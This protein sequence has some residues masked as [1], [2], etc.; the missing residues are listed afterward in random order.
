[1]TNEERRVI[2]ALQAHTGGLIVT[3]Q[4]I[5]DAQLKLKETLEGPP[6]RPSSR[7]FVL[8]AAAVVALIAG[9]VGIQSL[10]SDDDST[11]PPADQPADP[12]AAFLTGAMP[13]AQL[14]QG[15][16]IIGDDSVH[17]RFSSPN[18]V[19]FDA[20]GTL[21]HGPAVQGTYAI[22]GDVVSV[23]VDGGYKDCGSVQFSMRMRMAGSNV[24]HVVPTRTGAAGDCALPE[25]ELVAEQ[26]LP[27]VEDRASWGP[28]EKGDV[29]WPAAGWQPPRGSLVLHGD[30]LA[31]G[32]GYMLEIVADGTYYVV[33]ESGQPVDQGE[34]MLR[35]RELT[36]T[37]GTG[38][39]R[40]SAGD[41][42]VG[43]VEQLIV[44]HGPEAGDQ[45]GSKSAFMRTTVQQDGCGGDW[46]GSGWLLYSP[47]A[48]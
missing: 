3:D 19:S 18:V 4:D 2:D 15:V 48:G 36:L 39:V 7:P 29:D 20:E 26:L 21:F 5:H 12:H 27:T 41:R 14:L 6:K 24:A 8:A 10:G 37:S 45:S 23:S 13:T 25:G 33:D 47:F 30:W 28:P 31:L 34:W 1:M 42:L 16:W 46:A 9:F 32:G 11:A 35:D 40:C 44:I 17:M 38:S 43:A 22:E